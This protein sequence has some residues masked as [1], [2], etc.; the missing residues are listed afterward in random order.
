MSAILVQRAGAFG[1]VL[2][3]TPVVTRLRRENPN[4]TI[5][6][7]TGFP[8]VFEGNPDVSHVGRRNQHYD[9]VIDLNMAYENELR[10]IHCVDAYFKVAFGDTDGDK[11]VKFA[12]GPCPDIGWLIN[13]WGSVDPADCVVLHPTVSW[14]NRTLPASWYQGLAE[15]LVRRGHTVLAFGTSKDHQIS[16]HKIIDTRGRWSFQEQAAVLARAKLFIGMESGPLCMVGA[17]ETPGIGLFTVS[18]PENCHPYRHGK[19]AWRWRSIQAE[20]ECRACSARI[21]EPVTYVGCERNDMACLGTFSHER[22]LATVDD[23]LGSA[24]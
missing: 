13:R 8:Q 9:R 15:K 3:T 21:G 17:T 24:E 11:T 20:V 2:W 16:G 12:I 14:P 5:D 18:H 10:R 4:A 22:V 1:D 7:E 23:V 19:W 6:V